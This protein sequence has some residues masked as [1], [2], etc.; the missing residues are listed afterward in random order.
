MISYATDSMKHH[1]MESD[2]Y[3]INTPDGVM[4]K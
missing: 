3:A 4:I 2:L 1:I